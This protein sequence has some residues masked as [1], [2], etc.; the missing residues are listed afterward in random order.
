M[1]VPNGWVVKRSDLA[2]RV[3]LTG[4]AIAVAALAT[5][6]VIGP[7]GPADSARAATNSYDQITGIGTTDSSITVPWTQGL[8]N[9]SNQPITSDTT[10]LA[11][12]ADRAAGTG[13][14][15]F[16]YPDF[17][18]LV[19]TVSQTEDITHQGITVSWTGGEPTIQFGGVQGDFLQLMECYGD[20]DTGPDPEDCEYGTPGLLGANPQNPLIGQRFGDLCVAGAVP[21]T[22]SPPAALNGQGPPF[23]CDTEEPGSAT[24]SHI[25]P[26]GQPGTF[27][28]PFVPV[29]DPTDP[30][31]SSTALTQ[32]FN[33]FNT[34]E[35]QT[36]VTDTAGDGQAHFEALTGT[37]APGLGCGEPESNGQARNCWLVI[38][39]RGQYEPNGYQ[40]RG[41]VGANA[42]LDT[43]PL[44]ASNW[45]QRIQIHL[46]FATVP[47]YCPIGTN[48]TETVGTQIAARAVQ[49]WQLAL[50]TQADCSKI[51]GYSAVPEATSTQEL[52]DPS[53]GIGMAFTTIP[54]GSEAAR[55]GTATTTLPPIVYAPVAVSA[56]AFGFNINEQGG[57]VSTP[58][59]LT[60]EVL[61]RAL[62]QVYLADLPDYYPSTGLKGPAWAQGNPLN[63][64]TDPQFEELNPEV[65][66]FTASTE[67]LAPLLTEDHSALD[68]SV[69]QWIQ[70]DKGASA[71]L[72]GT[73]KTG[74]V[75]V[76]PDYEALQLGTAPAIDSFPRAY[77]SCLDLGEF[78]GPPP[79]E[80]VKCSLDLLPYANSY[81]S[82]ATSVLT[83][84]NPSAGIW[85]AFAT[86]PDGSAGWWDSD[87]PEQLG[88]VFMWTLGDTADLAAFGLID[89]QL[90]NDDGSDC[91]GPS[92]ASVTTA[93]AS[94]TA[95]SAGLLEVNPASPGTG[96]YPL[97]E[98][99]YA[100]VPTDQS[101]TALDAYAA[102][103]DYAA[104]PGQTPGVAPGDLP[105]GYLPLP[106]NLAN[107]AKSVAA[108]LDA[109]AAA[110]S[111]T[112]SGTPTAAASQLA[113]AGSSTPSPGQSTPAT[114]VGSS[115]PEYG[116]QQPAAEA[117]AITTPRQPVGAV[118]WALLA[119]ALVGAACATGGT[120]LRSARVPRWLHRLRP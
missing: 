33:E 1:T 87:G 76:D 39:P 94:A 30:A 59:K 2:R 92:T 104:G 58:V 118:R 74:P 90:C 10:D 6:V 93:L 13:P 115:S 56:L 109:D 36:A 120:V 105:P 63:I 88:D 60:P 29:N 108:E 12:N 53:S 15:S 95:D 102:L 38:V 26:G 96:G 113:G 101:A 110:Q 42:Y 34:N 25:A 57:F 17:Q 5:L 22:T 85:D 112:P 70:A 47:Q 28:V 80:E 114:A 116:I 44:S 66:P 37:E 11:S 77:S 48:E 100:A 32:Y 97:V 83:A 98:V 40:L 7:P 8:L 111:A 91:V 23:G 54:I 107:E 71:W 46:D 69:W 4:T 52:A 16:M 27:Y 35:V 73:D 21:S 68:Q 78:I 119:I 24:P 18:N 84:V 103:I 49:S 79:K 117:A 81:E 72:N 14:L 67:P 64:S 89:A 20:A 86:A 9:S 65:P 51:Y 19:V 75:A 82:A 99:T 106:A 45:A 55:D 43:S 50:N 62:T 3:R 61:A 41:V 31:Y